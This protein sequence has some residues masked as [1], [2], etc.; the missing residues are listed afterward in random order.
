[1]KIRERLEQFMRGRYGVDDLSRFTL[2]MI[3]VVMVINLFV[4][5]ELINLVIIAAIVWMYVRMLSKNIR[6]RYEENQKFLSLKRRLTGGGSVSGQMQKMRARMQDRKS[7]HIYRCPSC[8]Q[9]I[10]IPRGRGH[11]IVTCPKCH[12]EFA[13]NS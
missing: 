2:V 12:S 11:I 5:S 7:N 9:K 8:G 1:M 13:R 10:R 6:A 4:R 3:A